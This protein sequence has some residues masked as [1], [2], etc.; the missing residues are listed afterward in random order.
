MKAGILVTILA[1]TTSAWGQ[2]PG[3]VQKLFSSSGQSF[4][5][6]GSAVDME[7]GR[8]VVGGRLLNRVWIYELGPDLWEESASFQ[9]PDTVFGDCF[10]G[11][12]CLSGET[13]LIG[14]QR[15]SNEN[16]AQAGSAY[17]FTKSGSVWTF[18]S[19]LLPSTGLP[20]DE[21]GHDVALEG[22]TAV[23]GSFGSPN[24]YVYERTGTTW[25]EV[26]VISVTDGGWALSVALQSSAMVIGSPN[27]MPRGILSTGAVYTYVPDGRTWSQEQT[28]LP[29]VVDDFGE[30]GLVLDVSGRFLGRRAVAAVRSKGGRG[31]EQQEEV[32]R[33][34]HRRGGRIR[35]L[36]TRTTSC[37][38]G[39]PGATPSR[40]LRKRGNAYSGRSAK[41]AGYCIFASISGRLPRLLP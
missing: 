7:G 16:G 22:D 32:D 18:Q 24:A 21:T 40:S 30:F 10:G 26:Q 3:V 20:G 14:A 1:A 39:P 6:F 33:R 13:L 4:E 12:V 17:V 29:S 35:D 15:D 19:K 25:D 2:A 41:R 34:G 5:T 36:R 9:G 23:L 28:L 37:R 38:V 8:S 27:A 31:G 11:A